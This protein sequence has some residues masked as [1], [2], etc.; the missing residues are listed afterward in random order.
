MEIKNKKKENYKK[1][2]RQLPYLSLVFSLT[3]KKLKFLF[4][5]N[6]SERKE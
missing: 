5:E 6:F 4:K 2:K 3:K 1:C